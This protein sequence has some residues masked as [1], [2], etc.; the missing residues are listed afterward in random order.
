MKKKYGSG[1]LNGNQRQAE[2]AFL[3]A[4]L[5]MD[6]STILPSIIQIFQTI[7]ELCSRNQMLNKSI[8]SRAINAR[9]SEIFPHQGL[10]LFDKLTKNQNLKKTLGRDGEGSGSGS[11]FKGGGGGSRTEG[12]GW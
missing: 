2:L 10:N 6:C 11:R 8:A 4:T 9:N 7:A 12:E 3:N 5:H 1:H